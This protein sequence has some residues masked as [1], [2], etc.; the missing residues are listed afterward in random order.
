M[1]LL[2]LGIVAA[3]VLAVIVIYVLKFKGNA[4]QTN[5]NR[6]I[7]RKESAKLE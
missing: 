5:P 4:S 6:P 1:D 2:I 3:V 7:E